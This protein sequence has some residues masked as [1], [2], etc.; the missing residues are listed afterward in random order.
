MNEQL[1]SETCRLLTAQKLPRWQELPDLELYMDQVLG[2]ISRYL[3]QYPGFDE[4]GLTAAMVNNYVK[5]GVLPPPEKK[6]YQRRHI[7]FLLVICILKASLPI[8]SIRAM[9]AQDLSSEAEDAAYDHFCEQFEQA[10]KAAAE[11]ALRDSSPL[12]H[13][14]LRAQAE[15]ALA[16]RLCSDDASEK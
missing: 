3:G 1:L 12:Y 13:A 16:R 8:A 10:C 9:I 5:M 7:A 15:Q 6:R 4:K 2:L 14:A 11:S